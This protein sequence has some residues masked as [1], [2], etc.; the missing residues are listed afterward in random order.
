MIHFIINIAFV[1]AA[2]LNLNAA[3]LVYT[4]GYSSLTDWQKTLKIPTFDPSRG[5]LK[6]VSIAWK[7]SE[8][9]YSFVENTDTH[10]TTQVS[11]VI[12]ELRSTGGPLG[13]STLA[14]LSYHRT[15]TLDAFDGVTDFAGPSGVINPAETD[16]SDGVSP[17][18][19]AQFTGTGFVDFPFAT[20][21]T[22][23]LTGNANN[24][25]GVRTE[26]SVRLRVTYCYTPACRV[27][28]D[29]CV[30]RRAF[31]ERDDDC[32]D[33]DDNDGRYCRR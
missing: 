31:C 10:S 33:R 7:A 5:V 1:F 9:T 20:E 6:S 24:A 19:K 14:T 17:G 32:D 4:N 27:K 28:C 3:V 12:S 23:R 22:F 21:T 26:A 11:D 18:T 15:N 29:P 2:T 16:S 13:V 8:T 30:W 25:S